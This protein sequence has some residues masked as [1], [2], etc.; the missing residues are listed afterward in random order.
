[1]DQQNRVGWLLLLAFVYFTYITLIHRHIENFIRPPPP[2]TTLPGSDR[3]SYRD[4]WGFPEL[5]DSETLQKCSCYPRHRF[6]KEGKCWEFYGRG[7]RGLGFNPYPP[8]Y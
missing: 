5:Y 8:C 2:E 3:G 1:M 7:G 6:Y 4:Y